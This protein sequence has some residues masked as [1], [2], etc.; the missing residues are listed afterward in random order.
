MRASQPTK[1]LTFPEYYQTFNSRRSSSFV[2]LTRT[3]QRSYRRPDD[4][5]GRHGGRR[6]MARRRDRRHSTQRLLHA[7]RSGTPQTLHSN[8]D[9]SWKSRSYPNLGKISTI[10]IHRTR[11]I[12]EKS[13]STLLR[14][15]RSSEP[16]SFLLTNTTNS[17]IAL[18]RFLSIHQSICLRCSIPRNNCNFDLVL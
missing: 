5:V 13:S 12:S 4:V 3:V 9:L 6:Q 16:R 7:P 10:T 11:T 14:C 15:C 1:Q 18:S 8:S 17:V 2:G